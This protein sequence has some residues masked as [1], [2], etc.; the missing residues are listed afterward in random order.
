MEHIVKYVLLGSFIG[1]VISA[2]AALLSDNNDKAF[3]HNLAAA[4]SFGFVG[5]ISAI[6]N[7]GKSKKEER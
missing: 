5:V 2:Y 1:H 7:Y 6:Q 4:I 3:S